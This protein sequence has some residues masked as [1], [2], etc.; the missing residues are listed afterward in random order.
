MR[1]AT[2]GDFRGEK[3]P[4]PEVQHTR[5]TGLTLRI[6]LVGGL[7]WGWSLEGVPAEKAAVYRSIRTDLPRRLDEIDLPQYKLRECVGGWETRSKHFV[8]FSTNSRDEAVW[9]IREMEQCWSDIFRLADPWTDVHRKP[10]FGIGAVNVQIAKEAVHPLARPAAGPRKMNYY[11]DIYIDL[12]DGPLALRERRPQIRE[13]AFRAFM[14]A[15]QMEQTLPDWV[16]TGLATYISGAPLPDGPTEHLDLPK[17]VTFDE[18]GSW[19]RRT[20]SDRMA[21]LAENRRRASLWV[22]YLLEGNDAR[23]APD[24]FAALAAAVEEQPQTPFVPADGVRG[25]VRFEPRVRASN[26]FPLQDLMMTPTVQRKLP[27]WLADPM[28]GQPTIEPKS[29]DLPI[30]E[31]VRKMVLILKL[32]KRF[33]ISTAQIVQPKVY[34]FDA[35]G[36]E[37]L[38][39]ESPVNVG[40]S[41]LY[42]RLIDPEQPHWATLDT[43]GRLLLWSDHQRLAAIFNDPNVRY[44]CYRRD[45]QRVLEASFQTG[46]TFEAKLVDNPDAPNRPIARVSR[47]PVMENSAETSPDSEKSTPADTT[48]LPSKK[49]EHAAPSGTSSVKADG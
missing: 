24:F 25:V 30:D 33:G 12:A 47:K 10:S 40:L 21:P 39:V 27:D 31:R 41:E 20:V 11:T 4:M 16:Q 29:A 35:A 43:D 7:F 3:R 6:I 48:S 32:I 8:V 38:E 45:G 26:R 34:E 37:P 13:E 14:R 5:L 23:Y 49:A 22:K 42:R 9:A 44:R 2:F 46:E 18:T 1:E 15:A 17:P 28:A 19:A 36:S